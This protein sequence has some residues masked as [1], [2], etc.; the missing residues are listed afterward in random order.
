[1][2]SCVH[3]MCERTYGQTNMKRTITLAKINHLSV[4]DQRSRYY[5][6]GLFPA[7]DGLVFHEWLIFARV[8]ALFMKGL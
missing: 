1:M 3:K 2:T 8:I 7:D 4:D 6:I 5:V